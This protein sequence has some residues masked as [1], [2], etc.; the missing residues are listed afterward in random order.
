[1]NAIPV[2]L[3]NH[4]QTLIALREAG[5]SDSR[6]YKAMSALYDSDHDCRCI[7]NTDNETVDFPSPP[8]PA[9]EPYEPT[10]EDLDAREKWVADL[11]QRWI[12]RNTLVT[13]AMQIAQTPELPPS[14]SWD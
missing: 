7:R 1:M 8:P 10:Q 3:T 5:F 11:E 13:R 4:Y 2:S 12:D 14:G 6:I 9:E